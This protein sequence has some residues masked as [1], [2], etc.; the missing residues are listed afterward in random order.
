MTIQVEE[1][2]DWILYFLCVYINK[3]LKLN[4]KMNGSADIW[5]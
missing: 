2:E 3:L 5:F 1:N 4:P